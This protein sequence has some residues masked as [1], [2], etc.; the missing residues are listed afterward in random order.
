MIIL[1]ERNMQYR[2]IFLDGRAL[3]ADPNPT[4][5]GYSVG[6]WDGDTLVIQ[7]TGFRDDLWLDA[8]GNPLTE[9]GKT[10]G[11]IRRPNFGRLEIEITVDDPKA[12]TAPWTVTL[13]EPL[14][15]DSANRC[16]IITAWRTKKRLH[17]H[18]EAII[19][20]RKSHNHLLE[21]NTLNQRAKPRVVAHVRKIGNYRR[22]QY[23][24]FTQVGRS[25]ERL[26][27]MGMISKRRP[28]QGEPKKRYTFEFPSYSV[29]SRWIMREAFLPVSRPAE[30]HHFEQPRSRVY[31][32]ELT[33][34]LGE[35]PLSLPILNVR[36]VQQ[37][38]K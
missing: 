7:T 11:K 10:N 4:W 34:I 37:E 5:N 25:F 27:R 30:R 6:K 23:P 13:K 38:L 16:S 24:E 20:L 9:K 22:S 14:I 18:A 33:Q 1:T 29:S 28:R 36:Q 21:A 12:Y 31:G 19:E 35:R 2:Q 32:F 3:P 15:L 26:Q 17:S 8:N